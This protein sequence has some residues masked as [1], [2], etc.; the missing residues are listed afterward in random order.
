LATYEY[1]T[2]A[3]CSSASRSKTRRAAQGQLTLGGQIRQLGGGT[4]IGL[5]R[6]SPERDSRAAPGTAPGTVVTEVTNAPSSRTQPKERDLSPGRIQARVDPGLPLPANRGPEF[7]PCIHDRLG[8]QPAR[9]TGLAFAHGRNHP[10]AQ[11]TAPSARPFNGLN[12][13]KQ[14]GVAGS[15][16]LD[17]HPGTGIPPGHTRGFSGRAACLFG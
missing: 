4:S 12:G 10:D 11:N 5:H 6:H 2:C 7:G 14:N 15:R 1:D 16:N 3:P 9:L 17:S 8:P 13:P